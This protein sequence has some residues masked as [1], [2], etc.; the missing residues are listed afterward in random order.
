MPTFYV[1]YTGPGGAPTTA[2]VESSLSFRVFRA[3]A[4]VEGVL[5]S[6]ERSAVMPAALLFVSMDPPAQ[7]QAVAQ[8]EGGM[9]AKRRREHAA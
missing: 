5:L 3:A 4:L 6:D 7:V 1:T 8:I 2:V 9:V